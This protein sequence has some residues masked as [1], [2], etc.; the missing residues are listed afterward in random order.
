MIRRK[1]KRFARNAVR[2]RMLHSALGRKPAFIVLLYHQIDPDPPAYLSDA[3]VVTTPEA[4]EENL[5][6]AKRHF[7]FVH[8]SEGIRRLRQGELNESCCALTL[9]DGYR[10]AMDYA[11][12]I[13]ERENIPCT[14]FINGDC[15]KGKPLWTNQVASL[16]AHDRTDA[17][18]KIFGPCAH[19]PSILSYLRHH[20][21]S[22][23]LARYLEPCEIDTSGFDDHEHR[24][25]FD[26]QYVKDKL[27]G[28][29]V[30]LGN[31]SV[32][33]PRFS[34]LPAELQG[35][36]L[37]ENGKTLNR[38]HN[39]KHIFA[40]PFGKPTDWNQDTIVVVAQEKYEFTTACGGLNFAQNTGVDIRRIP[41][42]G[43]TV[44]GLEEE[45]TRRGLFI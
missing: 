43:T 34:R 7:E 18:E 26:E 41:C 8:F 25:H 38:F 9:D 31:H 27:S 36:Q 5:L 16:Q 23:E 2:S 10:M 12:P 32:N 19:H 6:W 28:P 35:T 37:V 1:L 33:H 22:E 15:L 20:G 17:L 29:L 44:G 4:F 30:E 39:F 13:L 42:D 14:L 24:A 11:M 45:I 3:G 21:T 40:L